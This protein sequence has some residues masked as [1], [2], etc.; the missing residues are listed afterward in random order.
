MRVVIITAGTDCVRAGMG[1]YK[2]GTPLGGLAVASSLDAAGVL[3]QHIDLAMDRG[4]PVT[5]AAQERVFARLA[6]ELAGQ[7]ADIAWIGLSMLAS[8]D[9]ALI[10]GRILR[11]ALPDLPIVLG[12]Y[13]PSS[14]WE[15]LLD[16]GWMTA[17]VVGDGEHA[18]AKITENL[19]AGRPLSDGV[20]NLAVRADDGPRLARIDTV[21]LDD[22]PPLNLALLAHPDR[23]PTI[24]VVT[25]RG[26]PWRCFFC[27][28]ESMRGYRAHSLEHVAAQLDG[29]AR[30]STTR[31]MYVGDPVFG[32]DAKRLAA[33]CTV[34]EAAPY[35]YG[36]ST[37]VDVIPPTLVPRLKR[38]GFDALYVGLESASPEALVRM[39]KVRTLPRAHAYV[40]SAYAFFQALFEND[41]TPVIGFL[42]G[43]PG[44]S[45]ADYRQCIDFL[46]RLRGIYDA[47]GGQ[48]GFVTVGADS[49]EVYDSAALNTNGLPADTRLGPETFVGLRIV[50]QASDAVD[51]AIVDRYQRERQEWHVVTERARPR[52]GFFGGYPVAELVKQ[53]AG[54]LREGVLY[55]HELALGVPA[56]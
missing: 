8:S 54:A 40:D 10:L 22:V 50:E 43:Y 47:S 36:A 45:E 15:K 25:T 19:A 28:E 14:C 48:G 11:S 3:V 29:A 35:R 38:A 31:M 18:A 39:N 30:S 5:A 13:H 4:I 56:S 49:T 32:V 17:I 53:H 6:A 33:L 46:V 16:L 24:N 37:R 44:D 41:I 21:P 51:R 12:G 1:G 23:Y 20:P 27:L 34:L 2:L 7:A 55:A 42:F 9:D 52:L 26:C